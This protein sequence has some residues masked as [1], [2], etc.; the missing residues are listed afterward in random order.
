MKNIIIGSSGYIGSKVSNILQDKDTLKLHSKNFDLNSNI[1]KNKY[2][3][4]FKSSNILYAA[5]IK[6]TKSLNYDSFYKNIDQFSRFLDVTNN[7]KPNKIILCS[8]I[9]VYGRPKSRLNEK[10]IIEPLNT[11]AQA[12]IL[13]EKLL[14]Y[15]SKKNKFSYVIIRIPGIYGKGDNSGV[16][17]K[18]VS[19]RK[20]TKK[21]T[22]FGS[23]SQKRDYVYVDDLSYIINLLLN[24]N[25]VMNKTINICTGKS[26][27]IKQIIGFIERQFDTKLFIDK[28]NN[29]TMIANR[30]SSWY[31]SNFD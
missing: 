2:L 9:E 16:V 23:G 5:G 12:K 24:K 27:T 3:K 6:R 11:Y 31:P 22:I 29:N 8:S 14:K 21:F 19:A 4:F 30:Q 17:N 15:Y 13:Q 18:I 1:N 10:S 7:Y 25:S 26:F 20:K 28:S